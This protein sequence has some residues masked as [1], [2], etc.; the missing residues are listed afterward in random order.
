MNTENQPRSSLK[1]TLQSN[2][3]T[4]AQHYLIDNHEHDGFGHQVTGGLA[5]NIV[6]GVDQGTDGLHLSLQLGVNGHFWILG[7]DTQMEWNQNHTTA[8]LQKMNDALVHPSPPWPLVL[9]KHRPA[10]GRPSSFPRPPPTVL[11][12][13]A[14]PCL[15]RCSYEHERRE[16]TF[17]TRSQHPSQRCSTHLLLV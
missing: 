10:G 6:V 9:G 2:S 7:W 14:G 17:T 12:A 16:G 3:S 15:C 4:T 8:V 1:C 13:P 11:K 5:D